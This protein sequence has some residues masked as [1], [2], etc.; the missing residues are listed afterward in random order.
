[1]IRKNVDIVVIGAGPGGA[2][3]A[4]LLLLEGYQVCLVEVERQNRKVAR[5]EYFQVDSIN[6]LKKY[7]LL[8]EAIC[9]GLQKSQNLSIYDEDGLIKKNDI[10]ELFGDGS[11]VLTGYHHTVRDILRKKVQEHPAGDLMM[12]TA[13]VDFIREGDAV[14]GVVCDR[15]GERVE[16]YAKLTIGA[17]GRG[18]KV[19]K[20]LSPEMQTLQQ[21]PV[22]AL[23]TTLPAPEDFTPEVSIRISRHSHPTLI[24]PL[25]Q[26]NARIV[27]SI[28]KGTFSQLVKEHVHKFY[29]PISK[30]S[31]EFQNSVAGIKNWKECHPSVFHYY[32][33]HV[34]QYAWDGLILVGDAA[35]TFTPNLGLGQNMALKDAEMLKETV[36]WGFETND[37]SR[38]NLQ[39]FEERTMET[40]RYWIK[41]DIEFN[42]LLLH[43]KYHRL[44]YEVHRRVFRIPSASKKIVSHLLGR[45]ESGFVMKEVL[46]A[47]GLL[48]L[49]L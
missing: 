8:E 38:E 26:K 42:R 48:P 30:S 3:A 18:S 34:G 7:D 11:F 22:Q 45:R 1:M 20:K 32:T 4:F 36:N 35:H 12:G 2:M 23:L 6:L 39:L 19:R 44:R 17:D 14:I 31:P 37:F 13:F 46:Q 5:G 24:Y 25:D 28:E 43:R 16:I 21:Y 15:A 33:Q 47:I 41:K 9:S 29:D 27:S 10:R 49:W 40:H